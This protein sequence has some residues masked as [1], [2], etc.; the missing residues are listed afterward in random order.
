VTLAQQL[1]PLRSVARIDEGLG[2]NGADVGLDMGHQ[3]ARRKETGRNRNANTPSPR[4]TGDDRPGHCATPKAV[5]AQ[6]S[7][8]SC[9]PFRAHL[10][11][12]NAY[13]IVPSMPG[14]GTTRKTSATQRFRQLSE[15][16]ETTSARQSHSRP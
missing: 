9:R 7:G 10:E 5:C 2:G 15:G 16:L 11:S 1:Q 12:S 13:S 3:R 14:I 6:I 4:V 8:V